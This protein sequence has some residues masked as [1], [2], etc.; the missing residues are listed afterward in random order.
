MANRTQQMA[1]KIRKQNNQAQY[2]LIFKAYVCLYLLWI[3]LCVCVCVGL[4]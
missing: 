3:Y 2:V 1:L 4:N